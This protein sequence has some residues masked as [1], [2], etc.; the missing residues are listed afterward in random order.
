[1]SK[2]PVALLIMDGFGENTS[3]YAMQLQL[4]KLRTLTVFLPPAPIR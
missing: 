4:R 3:D 1:M 2:K